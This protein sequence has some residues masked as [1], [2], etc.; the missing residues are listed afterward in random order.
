MENKTGAFVVG[1]SIDNNKVTLTI[2]K[3]TGTGSVE[4]INVIQGD[5]ALQLYNKLLID[6]SKEKEIEGDE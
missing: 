6:N 4:L 3:H 2:G 5:E 1:F